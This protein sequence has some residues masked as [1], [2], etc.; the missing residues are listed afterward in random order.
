MKHGTVRVVHYDEISAGGS[1]SGRETDPSALSCPYT[2]TDDGH[3]REILW[4]SRIAE[5][6]QE[7]WRCAIYLRLSREDEGTAIESNSIRNQRVLLMDYIAARPELYF[8][9]EWVDDGYSGSSFE[10]PALQR[11]LQAARDGKVDCI[12][13]KDLSRFGREY[14]QTGWYLKKW[15][16]QW[17]IRFIAVADH[18]DS[19]SALFGEKALLLPILNLMNDAYCRDIS[20]KVKNSQEARRRQ[21]DYV[22]AF[23][24][25]G[26]Q[27]AMINK[28]KL[29]VDRQTADVVQKIF[30][31]KNAGHSAEKICAFL[32]VLLIPSPYVYKKISGQSYKSGFVDRRKQNS[33]S[34]MT[35][36]KDVN[37]TSGQSCLS[38]NTDT[39]KV[40]LWSPVAVRRILKNQ[41]Y[42]GI[43]QQGKTRKI[44]YKLAQR[45]KVPPEEWISTDKA[46]PPIIEESLFWKC[47]RR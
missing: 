31:W 8:T 34:N 19:A 26:Y 13:V 40:L 4:Q 46:V 24:P 7:I 18:Y 20:R 42:I 38:D 6:Q 44:N 10:R 14:I 45:C 25:Y 36:N 35:N 47:Q 15:F 2:G 28:H 29:V 11:M 33:L 27:K 39:Q 22:G 3:E 43:L 32:N 30:H 21:G 37:E 9:G 41:L 1:V 17:G 23:A 16:P 12:L 5:R